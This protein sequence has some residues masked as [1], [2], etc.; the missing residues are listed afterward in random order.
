MQLKIRMI[1]FTFK[2]KIYTMKKLLLLGVVALSLNS[3]GQVPNYVPSN[4]LAGWWPFNGDA[5]DESVNTNNGTVNGATLA[6]D[7]FG[8][9]NS[10][11]DFDGFDDYIVV[12]DASELRISN[13][14]FTIS[15][16][17]LVQQYNGTS[18]DII[19][20]R[21]AYSGGNGYHLLAKSNRVA[22]EASGTTDPDSWTQ[23]PLPIQVW[24]NVVC[25]FD[26]NN[27]TLS[28]YIN[29]VMDSIS[30]GLLSPN[31]V[32]P[33]LFI[34]K[35]GLGNQY[36]HTGKIDDIGIWNRAL[37]PCE[38]QDLYSSQLNTISVS[39]GSDQTI[40]AGAAITLFAS[41][42]MNYS[43][44]N[45]VT[46]GIAFNPT[47]TQD[48][49]VDADSAGCVSSDVVTITVNQSSTNTINETATDTYTSPS[50]MV[51]TSSGVYNDTILN[52]NQ[53][54]SIITIN[55]TVAYTGIDEY[56]SSLIKIYPNPASDN[57]KIIGIEKLKNVKTFEITSITGARVAKRDVYSS[58][59]D[60]SSLDNGIYL[61]VI[62]HENGT[63]KIR[64]IKD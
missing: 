7:R 25:V 22:F 31:N 60:I 63:E 4:G 54:D 41:G 23:A 8:S 15:C 32:S 47:S 6:T 19:S 58:V 17:V 16:W 13:T 33:N 29:G 35:D 1:T 53:C 61:F 49:I 43:W 37:T 42:S 38:I 11:Y 57:F 64:F 5:N 30:I 9:P 24:S 59:I 21:S 10:A 2:N 50:G 55:L 44:N 27:S 18:N 48:Y 34:G 36:H 56:N 26:L 3:F 28:T 62:S 20:K 46:D 14:N 45:G 39:A 51:Y 12:N 52:S 40:C